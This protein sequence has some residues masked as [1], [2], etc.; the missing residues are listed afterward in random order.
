MWTPIEKWQC[1]ECGD[2]HDDEDDASECCKP[3]IR[4][5]YVCPIC[6]EKH[7]DR[8]EAMECIAKCETEDNTKTYMASKAELERQ[9]Q[10]RLF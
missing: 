8:E 2:I 1:G 5:V 4:E 10:E 3:V 9:G 7:G 6:N